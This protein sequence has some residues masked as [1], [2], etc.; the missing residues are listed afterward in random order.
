MSK[1]VYRI[2]LYG[3]LLVLACVDVQQ[4]RGAEETRILR[5]RIVDQAGRPV[6]NVSVATVWGSNG[7]TLKQLQHFMKDDEDHPELAMNEGRMEPWGA[8]PALTDA[9][10][11][12]AIE[13]RSFRE[14]KLMAVDKE[15]KRGALITFDQRNLPSR[16]EGQL[17]PLV[18]VHGRVRVAATG[19]KV[20]ELSVR[21]SIPSNEDSPL[22]N[23]ALGMCSSRESRF[24]FWFPPGAYGFEVFGLDPPGLELAKPHAIKL[25]EDQ[26]EFD[27]GVF[28]L[29]PKPRR[30][31]EIEKAK[32]A[33]EWHD[34]TQKYGQQCPTWHVV[35]AR[36]IPKDAQAEHFRGKWVL[37]YFWSPSCAPC[38]GRTLPKLHKFYEAHQKQRD[39]FE[40]VS[41]CVDMEGKLKS[42]A[43]FDLLMKPIV[44]AVWNGKALPFPVL[45]DNSYETMKRFG[46]EYFGTMLLIDPKGRLVQGDQSTLETMLSKE[47]QTKTSSPK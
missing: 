6:A 25:T 21:A 17:V 13:L 12:F 24:E 43:D 38:M 15:R 46:V 33:G 10:G 26:R 29:I 5:G 3:C 36:G 42:M 1:R 9:D 2:L 27:C 22:G 28:D 41:I 16:I 35:D 11:N 45:L 23:F 44:K 30:N 40:I 18:R 4:A 34:F 19:E 31:N 20:R 39:R 8:A 32:Q 47:Q 37:V 7:V 14:C